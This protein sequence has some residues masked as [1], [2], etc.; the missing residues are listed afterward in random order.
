[1]Y[2][3]RYK[4]DLPLQR[5]RPQNTAEHHF[6][7]QECLLFGRSTITGTSPIASCMPI[8]ALWCGDLPVKDVEETVAATSPIA[9]PQKNKQTNKQTNDNNNNNMAN[10]AI[11]KIKG[12]VQPL[13]PPHFLQVQRAAC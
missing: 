11:L 10:D 6:C 1:M 3:Q 8:I 4:L 12:L 5:T 9:P 13:E 2:V 7:Y